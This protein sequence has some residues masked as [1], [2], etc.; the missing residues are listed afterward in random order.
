MESLKQGLYPRSVRG[1]HPLRVLLHR[2][3][4]VRFLFFTNREKGEGSTKD[5]TF[6]SRIN[7]YT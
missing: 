4:K 7:F 1:K 6:T 2:F 5:K 3:K